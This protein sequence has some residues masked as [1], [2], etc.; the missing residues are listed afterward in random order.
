MKTESW[1][2]GS[3]CQFCFFH[4]T[5]QSKTHKAETQRDLMT[6]ILLACFHLCLFNNCLGWMLSVYPKCIYS[7]FSVSFQTPI[8]PQQMKRLAILCGSQTLVNLLTCVHLAEL[9]YSLL[10][11]C[12]S[13][14]A[15]WSLHLGVAIPGGPVEA[16]CQDQFYPLLCHRCVRCC[17]E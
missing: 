2:L 6:F 10:H 11:F 16:A 15:L 7:A 8:S 13:D 3:I 14:S 1:L 17:G 12:T 9:V 4:V 5:C